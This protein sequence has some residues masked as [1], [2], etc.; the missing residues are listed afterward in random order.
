MLPRRARTLL[1][2]PFP[3]RSLST[4]A[5]RPTATPD[6]QQ[7]IGGRAGVERKKAQYQEK[8]AAALKAKA[9]REGLTAEELVERAKAADVAAR[10]VERSLLGVKDP[11]KE[12]EQGHATGVEDNVENPTP[13][14]EGG[15]EGRVVRPPPSAK[16]ARSASPGKE[17]EGPVKVSRTVTCPTSS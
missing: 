14:V 8:Y 9:E 5:P 4:S 2:S 13:G 17:K 7:L 6:W 1:R 12:G 15:V 11:V 10:A 16:P 3:L